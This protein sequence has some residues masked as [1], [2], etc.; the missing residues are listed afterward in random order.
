MATSDSP[1]SITASSSLQLISGAAPAFTPMVAEDFEA[2]VLAQTYSAGTWKAGYS[3][4]DGSQVFAGTKA[5]KI[6]AETYD[7]VTCGGAQDSYYGGRQTL[8]VKVTPG[9]TIWYRARVYFP[10]TFSWGYVYQNGLSADES[11]ASGCGLSS[12]SDGNDNGL[13]FLRLSESTSGGRNYIYL[14]TQRRNMAQPDRTWGVMLNNE[15]SQFNEFLDV[16]GGK[17]IPGTWQAIQLALTVSHT[18][19]G[20]MQAWIDDSFLGERTNINT[21]SVSQGG[22]DE[23]AIGTHF[24]GGH[25]SDTGDSSHKAF[26]VDDV[27]VASDMP[28]YG[29]PGTTDSGGRPFIDPSI[30]AGDFA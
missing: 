10:P 17:I 3:V 18:G 29:A 9:Y 12:D 26:Y 4:V 1:L 16:A 23:W 21:C 15:H 28:G 25:Y 2:Q 7:G 14:P 27:I 20:K 19:A 8:P 30:R 24:N 13:K 22:I 5:L 11:A 6:I